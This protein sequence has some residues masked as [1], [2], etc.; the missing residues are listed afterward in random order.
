MIARLADLREFAELE[1]HFKER[2]EEDIQVLARKTFAH[3]DQHDAIEWER[4]KAFYAGVDAVL[5]LPEKERNSQR[6]ESP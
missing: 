1:T 5:S 6:K 2:R 3:P 4:K